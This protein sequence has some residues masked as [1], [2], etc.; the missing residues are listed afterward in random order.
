VRLDF[1]PRGRSGDLRGFVGAAFCRLVSPP[2]PIRED[3]E[4]AFQCCLSYV[5][6]YEGVKPRCSTTSAILVMVWSSE[7]LLVMTQL[8]S[9]S[10]LLWMVLSKSLLNSCE[11]VSSKALMNYEVLTSVCGSE[12]YYRLPYLSRILCVVLDSA[13]WTSWS[14]AM[15]WLW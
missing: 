7:S 4:T 9:R 8:R 5:C 15:R 3:I 14:I 13:D 6:Q 12:W 10:E 11:V 1:P 2:A